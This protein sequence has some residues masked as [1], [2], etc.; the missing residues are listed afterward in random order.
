MIAGRLTVLENG[1]VG[2]G[3]S[4]PIQK[5]SVAGTVESTSG[6]FKFPDGSIQAAA[7]MLY[8]TQR[9]TNF[10]LPADLTG[11]SPMS[12]LSLTLPAD[13]YLLEA[14][15]SLL[16]NANNFNTDNSRNAKC[17]FSQTE[18]APTAGTT[19]S[20]DGNWVWLPAG[21]ANSATGLRR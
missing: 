10:E 17:W 21:S 4:S 18:V 16:N 3:N 19:S 1:N 7:S 13:T 20:T 9:S 2:I 12:V 5:L 15:I 11:S 14:Y 8:T 6:G